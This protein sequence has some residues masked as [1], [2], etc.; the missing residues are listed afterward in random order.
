MSTRPVIAVV[1]DE[2]LIREWVSEQLRT[3][4]YAVRCAE[5]GQA[6][7]QLVEEVAPALMVLDLRLPD[8]SGLELLQRLRDIDRDL[9][10]IMVTAYGEIETAV[11][12]VKAGA[13]QFLEK[14]VDLNELLVMINKALEARNLR[15]QVAALQQ[16]HRW[17]FANVE[18]VGRSSAMRVIADTVEKL[19]RSESATVLLQGESGTGKDL[20]ARAIH[21]RSPRSDRPFLAINCTALPENL[22]ESELFGHERGAF[23][24]ARERKK[25]LAE[26]A[27]GGTLFLDEIGDMP[28]GAQAKLLRFLEDSKFKR[29]GG[30]TD[31]RVDVRVIAATNRDLEAAVSKAS[32]RS[33]LYYRLKVVPLRLPP[34]RERPEDIT[35]LALYF[36]HQLA[37]DLRRDP[38]RLADATLRIFEAYRWPGNARELRNVL[39][40]LLILEDTEE[41]R[42]EHLPTEM[43][44]STVNESFEDPVQLP[45]EGTDL[46][47]IE[48]SL[49]RQALARTDGNVTA[50]ARLLGVTRDTLRYRLDKHGLSVRHTDITRT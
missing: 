36:L 6:A 4:G 26:L 39:E 49:L 47:Q 15:Q 19:A 27:D 28:P 10:V 35:P 46:E 8:V 37:Q 41:I 1:D 22:V 42:P 25:G 7:L 13:Y 23:T 43:T 31:V 11:A 48:R 24:D 38:P 17:Q 32:F 44:A 16:Q 14:P 12:A 50:A 34:L 33:D 45:P 21:A 5:D 30:M 18:L 9:V 2:A 3:A 40:R 29:L 20:I